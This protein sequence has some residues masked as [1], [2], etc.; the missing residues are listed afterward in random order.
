MNK[1][2]RGEIWLKKVGHCI[3]YLSHCHD[4]ISS[5]TKFKGGRVH[6]GSWFDGTA[7]RDRKV[8][9]Q[10]AGRWV[11]ASSFSLYPPGVP[12]PWSDATLCELRSLP[13]GWL[14]V[15]SSWLCQPSQSPRVE[16]WRVYL[17]QGISSASGCFLAA[18]GGAAL[19]CAMLPALMV[20]FNTSL[21]WVQ[22]TLEWHP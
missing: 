10:K 18:V 1:L 5:R 13:P 8:Y 11:S 6:F 12:S 21:Q 9:C 14:Q 2:L 17:S 16:L 22:M 4:K 7:L 20:C 19:L 15:L 3:R